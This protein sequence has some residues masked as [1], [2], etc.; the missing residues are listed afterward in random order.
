VQ[1]FYHLA[2]ARQRNPANAEILLLLARAAE[3]A[4][5]YD[6]AAT[7][8]DDY[9]RLRPGDDSGR[10]D[11][12]RVCGQ[13]ESRRDEARQELTWYLAKH[14]DD[15]LGHYAYAL[16]FWW[17]EPEKAL[18][19]LTE[20]ARLDPA[21]ASIRF[22][23]AWMLQRVGRMAESLPDL[24]AANRRAPGNVRILDLIGLAHLSL[25]RPIEAEK[26]FRQA[27][28]NT[29]DDPE[30]VM[31]MGR[32]LMAQ[33]REQEAQQFL[34]KYRKIRPQELPGLRKRIGMIDLATLPAAEQRAREIDRYRKEA[35]QHPDRPDYQL[36]LA[37]LLLA[38][39]QKEAALREFKHLLEFN[40]SSTVCEQAGEV[41]L[42][43]GE[44][45][46]AR[47][48]LQRAVED[49]PAARVNLAIAV[50]HERGPEA[51]LEVLHNR[52]SSEPTGDELLLEANLLELSGRPGEAVKVLNQGLT[53]AST[54]PRV[55]QTAVSSLVRLRRPEEALQ[56]LEQAIRV[57]PQDSSLPLSKGI[58][59]SVMGQ[60][61][62]AEKTFREVELRWPEW[63]KAYLAHGLL[64]E[65][66]NRA[67]PRG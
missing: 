34:D 36:H 14:P 1:A 28:A 24:E 61:T 8:Y 50:F 39:N 9:L 11:R 51:A 62:A 25:E 67:V 54:Q 42:S 53:H 37:S 23:R 52:Q 30:V 16:V 64:L 40:A 17:A 66:L 47:K 57:N 58:V 10:R 60:W 46:L 4:G 32:A 48:F 6:D 35:S 33:G 26:A 7:A 19:H 65:Q 49:R 20:A 12:A 31:H 43:A 45:G 21:S 5:Y 63:W 3:D 38:D 13:T 56:L 59:L 27:L 2:R 41:L 22:S 15:P 18:L 44:Y 55:V 29:P